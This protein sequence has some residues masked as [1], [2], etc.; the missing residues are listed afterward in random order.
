LSSSDHD[1]ILSAAGNLLS[2]F[3][4]KSEPDQDKQ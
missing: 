4:E 2:P 3:Q 1:A